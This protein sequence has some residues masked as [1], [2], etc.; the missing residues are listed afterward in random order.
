MSDVLVQGAAQ[1]AS[2]WK[3]LNL[4]V[5]RLLLEENGLRSFIAVPKV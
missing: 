1:I 3:T 5:S 2:T 4:N